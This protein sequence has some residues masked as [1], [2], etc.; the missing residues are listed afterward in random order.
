MIA[1]PIMVSDPLLDAAAALVR[2]G[3][4]PTVAAVAK[5]AGVSRAAIYRR[6]GHRDALL[7]ALVA[8]GRVDAAPPEPRERILDAVGAVIRR[9]GLAATTIEA[10]AREAAVGEATVY[11]R[12]GDRRGLLQAFVA[13]RTPR[14][15]AAALPLEGGDPEE[16][17]LLLTRENLVFLREHRG[18]FQLM[19]SADPEAR[20]LLAE[21]RGE[22]GSVREQTE[23]YLA[24]RFSD[25][26]AAL[27]FHG[28]LV[29]VAWSAQGDPDDDARFVVS[30]FLR[31]VR[32]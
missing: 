32:P 19:Y 23:R 17:L 21:A 2:A 11:R 18:L 16:D 14:R 15:V 20:A 28:L 10:V 7:A 30:T 27:A 9:Q 26:R 8:S 24:A 31:G 6:F 22:T 4:E 5:A 12:F 1:S 3:V 29:A 25:P 13:E